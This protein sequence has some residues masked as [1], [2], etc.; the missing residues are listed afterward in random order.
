[1]G[2]EKYIAFHTV[3]MMVLESAY[4]TDDLAP[5]ALQEDT[6]PPTPSNTLPTM[7]HNAKLQ[8]LYLPCPE[9]QKLVR[10]NVTWTDLEVEVPQ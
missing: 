6:I 1:M 2:K 10:V 4:P 9:F 3:D 8:W 7:V 5:L